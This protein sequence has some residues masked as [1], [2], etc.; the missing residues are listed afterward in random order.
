MKN[1]DSRVGKNTLPSAKLSFEEAS[2]QAYV[3]AKILH[4][5]SVFP[6]QKYR[7]PVRLLNT[8]Q[9]EAPGTIISDQ[10][11]EGEIKSVAAK[12]GI[13]AIKIQS[14]RML[15]A[16]GFLRKVFEVFER[17]KTPIDM[18]TTSEVA[19]RSEEHTSELQSLMRI[20]YADF[21]LKKKK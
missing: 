5:H 14:S 16:Y 20:S 9:P 13:C 15:L 1:N 10:R 11:S 17:Y 7:V 18:V 12:E 19:I 6:A 8:M 21:G 2:E 4:P 3:G